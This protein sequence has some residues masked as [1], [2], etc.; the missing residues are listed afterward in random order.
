MLV[1]WKRISYSFHIANLKKSLI[2]FAVLVVVIIVVSVAVIVVALVDEGRCSFKMLTGK[3]TG[4]R[5]LRRSRRGWED[6]MRTDLKEMCINTKSWIHSAHDR[7]LLESPCECGFHEP[8]TY[9]ICWILVIVMTMMMM[10]IIII[11]IIIM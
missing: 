2:L 5:T 3:P 9:L 1:D 6:N 4:K 7:D 10:M 11:I 8:W